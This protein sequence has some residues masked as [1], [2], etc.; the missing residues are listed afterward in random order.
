ME[1]HKKILVAFDTPNIA[2]IRGTIEQIGDLVGGVK[3]GL[4][5]FN[6]NGINGVNKVMERNDNYLF[7]DLKFHDIPNTVAGAIR[8]AMTGHIPNMINVH[9]AGGLEMMKKAKAQAVELGEQLGVTP[10]L[11]IGV[12]ILT[13]LDDNDMNEI[14][15]SSGTNEQVIKM[16]KLAKQAGLDGVVCSAF[17]IEAIKQACGD[18]F[19]LV[20]PGIRPEGA[21]AGD[22]KRIMTP[23]QALDKGADYIVIGRPITQAEDMKAVAQ[24]IYD[25]V[26]K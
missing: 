5:F 23:K 19:V 9:T 12:T 15:Y 22:Q 2:K 17:E 13:A 25:S 10:P 8:G 6:A 14:G 7:L 16:A 21:D 11:V 4:E 1:N 24:S 3:L 18:D 20:V 26:N